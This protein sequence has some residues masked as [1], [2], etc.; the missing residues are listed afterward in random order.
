M[1]NK[2]GKKEEKKKTFIESIDWM[3]IQELI[4]FHSLLFT[5]RV[6]RRNTPLYLREKFQLNTDNTINTP[7][8]RLMNTEKGYRWRVISQWNNMDTELRGELS[9]PRFKKSL[10]RWIMSRRPPKEDSLGT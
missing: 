7:I 10:K 2:G 6:L 1:D 3:D 4:E 8:P 5:W 9:F